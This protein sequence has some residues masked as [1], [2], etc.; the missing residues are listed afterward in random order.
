MG[1][2]KYRSKMCH[3]Y[4]GGACNCNR[5]GHSNDL[6]SFFAFGHNSLLSFA[7]TMDDKALAEYQAQHATCCGVPS[8]LVDAE[9]LLAKRAYGNSLDKSKG[10]A[11]L[12]DSL[13]QAAAGA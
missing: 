8:L 3:L 4:R 9:Q 11:T 5:H 13:Q 7:E 12:I 10:L 6:P 2:E 1:V